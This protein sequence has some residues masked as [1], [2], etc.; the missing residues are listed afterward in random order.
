MRFSSL[1]FAL[2]L[3][4]S[5]LGA[6]LAVEKKDL[7]PATIAERDLDVLSVLADVEAKVVSRTF[8]KYSSPPFASLR[9]GL[10][11]IELT[12]QAAIVPGAGQVL[13]IADIHAHVG[14]AFDAL[15]HCL[16]LLSVN[17]DV[18]AFIGVH[19]SKRELQQLKT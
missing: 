9:S 13:A 16:D 11:E 1:L 19:A 5:V 14:V 8:P 4:G 7:A 6:P 3:V 10:A 18:A 12:P 15:N 2:P 17:A